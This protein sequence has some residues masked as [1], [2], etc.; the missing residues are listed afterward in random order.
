MTS[1]SDEVPED[2]ATKPSPPAANEIYFEAPG[3][4]RR[5][6]FSQFAI[7]GFVISCISL[8]IFGI[9]GALGFALAGQ[10]LR[11]TRRGTARGRGLAIAGMI[12]G[13]VGFLF[14]AVN[15]IVRAAG[16]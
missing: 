14:Y 9:A 11:A 8:F 12:I 5:L 4:T 1:S 7:W 10:G 15:F 13:A 6:P 3:P 16:S 2:S